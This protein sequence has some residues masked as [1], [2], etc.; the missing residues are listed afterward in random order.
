M[1]QQQHIVAREGFWTAPHSSGLLFYQCPR[2]LACIPG[3]NGSRSA[4]ESGHIGLLCDVCAVGYALHPSSHPR[5]PCFPS[6]PPPP[7]SPLPHSPCPGHSLRTRF[8]NEAWHGMCTAFARPVSSFFEQY[9]KCTV[10]PTKE[11]GV[12]IVAAVGVPLFLVTLLGVTFAVRNL[13]PQGMLKVGPCVL[14]CG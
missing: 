2:S 13:L 6:S 5:R 4:C 12:S 9:G 14:C 7:P 10:C 11:A 3:V 8:F 1:V